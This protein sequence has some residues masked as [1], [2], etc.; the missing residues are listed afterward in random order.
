[1]MKK[2]L[3]FILILCSYQIFAQQNDAKYQ[4]QMAEK[5]IRPQIGPIIQ[6]ALDLAEL[7][8]YFH[9]KEVVLL[10]EDP[11][12]LDNLKTV[13]KFNKPIQ[14]LKSTEITKRKVKK[15]LSIHDWDITMNDCRL[16]LD[17]NGEGILVTYILMKYNNKWNITSYK[18]IPKK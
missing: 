11:F 4:K 6:A 10:E 17:F 16:E 12:T 2:C 9:S 3:L 1:M 18:I 5:V 15:Y 8:N 7:Q 14:V 13:T